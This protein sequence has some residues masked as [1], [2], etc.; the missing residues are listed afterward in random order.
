MTKAATR[1]SQSSL[2]QM[3]LSP[4]SPGIACAEPKKKKNGVNTMTRH[5]KLEDDLLGKFSFLSLPS[6]FSV[7]LFLP[8]GVFCSVL[9]R[10]FV[11]VWL[12]R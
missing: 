5:D 7:P 4:V 10:G 11:G 2:C 6:C 8:F 9:L 12:A 1:S 3:P